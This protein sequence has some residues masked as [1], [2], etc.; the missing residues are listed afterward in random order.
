[1]VECVYCGAEADETGD[2]VVPK[3]L[4]S[5]RP[6]NPVKVP[7]CPRC[8]NRDKSQLDTYF[9]D[10]L[11]L[12]ALAQ[13]HPTVQKI[14][15]DQFSRAKHGGHSKL[16]RTYA[17]TAV[18]RDV[19]AGTSYVGRYQV[20]EAVNERIEEEIRY[21]TKGLSF[22]RSKQRLP[23]NY[24]IDVFYIPAF[25]TAE[26]LLALNELAAWKPA[27]SLGELG[28]FIAL[29]APAEGGDRSEVWCFI[30]YNAVA[31]VAYVMD[32]ASRA[33]LTD[34]GGDVAHAPLLGLDSPKSLRQ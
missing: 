7:T 19:V 29:R 1:M 8:N 34:N 20:F 11:M 5:P 13:Q 15:A 6:T 12:D 16:S 17:A 24:Q 9:R 33:W 14:R 23:D 10:R 4:F 32:E 27:Y 21:V 25:S 22:D 18:E 3:C 28:E 31:Y 26:G 2:H 30:F